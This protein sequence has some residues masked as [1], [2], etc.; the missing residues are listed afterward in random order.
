MDSVPWQQGDVQIN[1]SAYY[2]VN[3]RYASIHQLDKFSVS[4]SELIKLR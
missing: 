2:K 3:Y 1:A 4:K